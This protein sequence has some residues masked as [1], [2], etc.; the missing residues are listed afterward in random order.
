VGNHFDGT[1][2][3]STII[4]SIL[5]DNN[6]SIGDMFERT[7]QFST[8]YPR[9]S[10]NDTLSIATTN[11]EQLALG[12]YKRNSG[13]EHILVDD[14]TGAVITL[15]ATTV[16][17]FAVNYSIQRGTLYR[18]GTISI[19]TVGAGG[20]VS[21]DEFVQNGDTGITLSITQVGSTVTISYT[22]TNTGTNATMFTSVTFLT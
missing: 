18:N 10:V 20:L 19:A 13:S 5:A 15:D 12:T 17:T 11:G 9:V 7:D 8:T 4:V 2:N 14:D 22:S 1:T 21:Q 3:P 6:N 16:K